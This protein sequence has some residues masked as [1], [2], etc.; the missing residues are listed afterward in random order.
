MAPSRFINPTNDLGFKK[1]FGSVEN[2]DILID[3]LNAMIYNG[4]AVI[5]DLTI[6]NPY[7]LPYLPGSKESI[8]D[9][10]AKLANGTK[11]LIE[12]QLANVTGFDLRVLYNTA[13]AYAEQLQEGEH[14]RRLE[15]VISLIITKFDLFPGQSNFRSRFLLR[16]V[17]QGFTYSEDFELIFVELPK[18]HKH[19]NE[20]ETSVD[21]WAF[22][23]NQLNQL[24]QLPTELVSNPAV[25]KACGV[26]ERNALSARELSNLEDRERLWRDQA[27]QIEFAL[28]QGIERGKRDVARRL[29]GTLP[30]AQIAE[31]TGLAIAEIEGL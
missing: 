11:V 19:L 10:K 4:A 2:T 17:D 21:Q 7:Q 20:L 25:A 14:Y 24:Q 26:A 9:I 31:I 18:F 27:G 1:I 30:I 29:L 5:E 23:L 12:M 6:L 16:E 3:F 8:L 28:E 15:P 22:F 13:K